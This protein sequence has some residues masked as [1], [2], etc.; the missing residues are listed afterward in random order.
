VCPFNK[1]GFCKHRETC[2]NLHV[3]D[4]CDKP[5]C[6]ISNCM[7]RHPKKCKFYTEYKRCKFDPCAYKH[8]ENQSDIENIKKE[9]QA[10]LDRID[11]V[12]KE[13]KLLNEKETEAK[14]MI[15][16]L[17]QMDEKFE[18][19]IKK[20]DE[21]IEN[22]EMKLKDTDLKAFEQDKK[23]ETLR[24][25]FNILKEKESTLF[26]L[27]L[28]FEH[29]E[30]KVDITSK[31]SEKVNEFKTT[32][33]KNVSTLERSSSENQNLEFKCDICEF[34][35]TSDVEFRAHIRAKHKD[36]RKFFKCWTCDFVCRTKLELTNHN[37]KYW[38]SHRMA[39]NDNHIVLQ[40]LIYPCTAYQCLYPPHYAIFSNV[41]L[42]F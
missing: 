19:L 10:L 36:S 22:L 35:A 4:L 17:N 37:D 15:E 3:K 20:R 30:K 5:S 29:L 25:K 40:L 41:V 12:D 28:K 26:E 31:L 33:V 23:I 2:R 21:K 16:K 8:I 32:N 6:D 38:Y 14:M 13:I 27:Q 24:R 7:L 9:N 1:Y 42:G 39:L 18:L 34:T 11:N